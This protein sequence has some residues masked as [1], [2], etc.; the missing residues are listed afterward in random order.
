MF[1]PSNLTDYINDCLPVRTIA[2]QFYDCD[3]DQPYY[4]GNIFL[5]S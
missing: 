4:V 1:G 5:N 2:A 3:D